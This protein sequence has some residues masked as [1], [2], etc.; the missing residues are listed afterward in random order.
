MSILC[1]YEI[2]NKLFYQNKSMTLF[3]VLLQLRTIFIPYKLC[4]NE[5]RSFANKNLPSKFF[6]S[7]PLNYLPL[8]ID[9]NHYKRVGHFVWPTALE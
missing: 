3:M 8:G 1:N 2:M 9:K 6:L 5:W 4:V 7:T